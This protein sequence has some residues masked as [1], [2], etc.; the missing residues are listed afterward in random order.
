MLDLEDSV[1]PADKTDETRER[2]VQALHAG[3]WFARTL[4][5]R[6]NAVGTPWCADD[7]VHLVLRAG[8]RIDCVVVPKVESADHVLHVANRLTELE[9]A[10]G[11]E[12]KI[13]IE[14]LIETPR[15]LV[16][17]ER[18]AGA[19]DRLESLVFGPGDFA[20]AL[21][22]PQ[23]SIGGAEPDYPGDV[24]HYALSRIVVAAR[25]FGLQA[26]DGP[27]AA[28]G[29]LAGFRGSARRS[30]LLGYDGKWVIHPE[31]IEP[32]NQ[33]YTPTSEQMKAA[34]DID[35]AYRRLADEPSSGVGLHKGE[36]IDEATRKMAEAVLARGRAALTG[37]E[38]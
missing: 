31:Q 4:A 20:A 32:C 13:A 22:M 2:V 10:N 18:I 9:N 33:I 16:E 12:R 35:S 34:E 8:A 29:D 17:V 21:G 25:A 5:V 38:E 27:Y 23:L 24:W 14:A 37:S 15:G 3:P 36:M 28:L 26:V 6:V 11:L 1:A 19:S 30:A 7:L